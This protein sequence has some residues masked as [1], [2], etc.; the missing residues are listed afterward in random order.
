VLESCRKQHATYQPADARYLQMHTMH[1][2]GVRPEEEKFLSP[3]FI[4]ATTFTATAPEL[5]DRIRALAEGGYDQFVVQLV[6]GHESALEDWVRVF[7][8]V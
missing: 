1:L 7:E 2:L 3:E 4:A 6:P 8:S 5:R